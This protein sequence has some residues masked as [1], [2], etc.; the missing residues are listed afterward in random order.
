MS[1][2]IDF[3]TSSSNYKTIISSNKKAGLSS[4]IFAK[5][6]LTEK[7]VVH[8]VSQYKKIIQSSLDVE[9]DL[10][11]LM[12]SLESNLKFEVAVGLKN[13][14]KE[15]A[16]ATVQQLKSM[17]VKTHMLTGDSFENAV[18]TATFLKMLPEGSD[19]YT[20]LDFADVN[21][22]RVKIRE[23]LEK[24]KLSLTYKNRNGK[25]S[26]YKNS[27]L[28]ILGS[29]LTRPQS[30]SVSQTLSF[31]RSFSKKN[32]G[33]GTFVQSFVISGKT[34]ELIKSNKYLQSH[35]AFI[36]MFT[37]SIVG[38]DF[39]PLHKGI[40]LQLMKNSNGRRVVMAVGD[41]VNDIPMMEEAH[42]GV[43]VTNE[44]T[45][46]VFGDLVVQRLLMIPELMLLEGSRFTSN[47]NLVV[48]NQFYFSIMISSV[49]FYYQFYS[50]FTA[51]AVMQSGLIYSTYA[52][53]SALCLLFVGYEN[54]YNSKVRT[55]LPSL[56]LEHHYSNKMRLNHFFLL[57]A[58]PDPVSR[59]HCLGRD[60]VLSISLLHD[61]R[62]RTQWYPSQ[63]QRLHHTPHVRLQHDHHPQARL[64]DLQRPPHALLRNPRFPGDCGLG[65][66]PHIREEKQRLG[67]RGLDP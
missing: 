52:G 21:D 65:P 27:G 15:D 16:I 38:F 61:P 53:Y 39:K 55:D 33:Q 18:N 62:D 4:L 54:T 66:L 49:Q 6:V 57:V 43:Q 23:V 1:N 14:L 40:L 2:I 29:P 19:G 47:L 45:N 30:S 63:L 51:S 25:E 58:P 3:D 9:T 10:A 34:I 46:M 32:T 5:K 35:F 7:E 41:G 8:V 22:G 28:T 17:N 67:L 31:Q 13:T 44:A 26:I 60:C 36:M 48:G 12:A 11:S 59:S 24:I 56:F 42:V 20:V 64:Q 50:G 37:S